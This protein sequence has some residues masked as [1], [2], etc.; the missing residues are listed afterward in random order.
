MFTCAETLANIFIIGLRMKNLSKHVQQG[1]VRFVG[2]WTGGFANFSWP[3][4]FPLP[5]SPLRDMRD[6]NII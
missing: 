1:K 6:C 2:G 5:D 3:F 4:P